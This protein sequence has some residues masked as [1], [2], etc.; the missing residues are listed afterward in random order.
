[1][2]GGDGEGSRPLGR[3]TWPRGEMAIG[4]DGNR[5]GGRGRETL[6]VGSVLCA[7]VKLMIPHRSMTSTIELHGQSVGKLTIYRDRRLFT[8]TATSPSS[9]LTT[10]TEMNGVVNELMLDG[11]VRVTSEK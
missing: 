3:E 9:F 10:V 4:G 6:G 1:M 11:F 2:D 8:I 5:G 7:N